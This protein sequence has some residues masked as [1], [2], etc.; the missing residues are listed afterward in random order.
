[1]IAFDAQVTRGAYAAH[2]CGTLG[3]FSVVSG[4]SGSGKST[5]LDLLAGLV[6]A[7][8][9][10]TL[11]GVALQALP[12]HRRGVGYA[13][14]DDRLFPHLTVE[15]NLRFGRRAASLEAVVDAL[16][17]EPLLARRPRELSGGERRRV[18]V[19]RAVLAAERLLLLDEP[20]SPLDARLRARVLQLARGVAT[21]IP[22][23]IV[24]HGALEEIVE[25]GSLRALAVS[26]GP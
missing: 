1:M 5:L 18:G 11:D 6:P 14:Q 7:R 19:G 21:T 17:L 2:Y 20:L 3:A 16:E 12:P 4:P 10:V 24:S 26:A 23:V 22:T 13:F 8:G 25:I 9:T 15:R